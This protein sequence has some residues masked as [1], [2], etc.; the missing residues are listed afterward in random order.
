MKK[1]LLTRGLSFASKKFFSGSILF[2]LIILSSFLQKASAQ[3]TLQTSDATSICLGESTTINVKICGGYSPWTVVY[4]DGTNNYTVT[5]YSSNCDPDAGPEV[6]DDITV[7]P[8]VTSTYTLVSVTFGGGLALETLSGSVTVTVNPLPTNIVVSPAAGVCPGVNFEIS[9]TATNGSTYE[10]WNAANTTKIDDLPYTTSITSNTNYTVRAISSHGCVASQSYTALLEDTPPS[11]SNPGAQTVNPVVGTCATT[12]PDYRSLVTVSDNCTATGSIALVQSPVAGTAISGHGTVQLVRITATDAAG[13]SNFSEFNVTLIDNIDPAISCVVNQTV[14]AS[15]SCT[16]T[17]SGTAWNPSG[18]DN[19]SVASVTYS[20]DNGATP[21]TGTTLN[22]VEFQPGTTTVTWTVTDGAGNTAECSFDVSIE[23]LQKP[24][25][26][27]YEDQ[28]ATT[29]AGLCS[30]TINTSDWDVSAE[31]NCT[32]ASV[33]YVLSGETSGT[34]TATLSGTTFNKGVTTVNVTVADGAA[35]P[36]TET[37]SFTVTISDNENPTIT[38]P[39]DISENVLSGCSKSI[40]I[41]TIVFG[42]NC[43]GSS[44]TWSSTGAT[45]LSGSGQPGAQTFDVGTT[46]VVVEVTDAANHKTQCS[47]NVVVSDNIEPTVTCPEDISANTDEGEN[48]ATVTVPDIAFSDNCTTAN[49]A[50][51]MSGATTRSGSDQIG[52]QTFSVGVTTVE[53]TVTDAADNVSTCSFDVTVT[54]NQNPVVTCPTPDAS[55]SADAGKCYKTLSFTATA[56][57]NC[58]VASIHYY[59]GS[60]ETQITFPYNF[61]VGSTEV[62]ARATDIN[63][64]TG[65][66]TF[67]VLVVDDQKPIISGCPS[68][69]VRSSSAGVCTAVVS[70]TEPTATDNCTA[71]ASLVKYRSHVPGSTFNP[72]IT[73]VKYAFTDVAG[74]VSDTCSFT[75]E[76]V[77]NQKPVI[78]GCPSNMTVYTSSGSCTATATWTEPTATDNCTSSGALVWTK[79]HSPGATFSTGTTTVTYTVKDGNENISNPCTFTVTVL[80]NVAPTAVCKN[81]TIDLNSSGN[82]TLTAVAVNNESSDNC[83]ATESLLLTLSKTS[84]NCSNIGDNT[85]TLTVRDASG[86]QA[87]CNSTVTVRDVTAPTITAT[88]GTV[89][90]TVNATSGCEYA[91]LGSEFDPVVTDNCSSVTKNY[92]VTGAT[93]LSGSG[94]LAGKVLNK[95]ANV[96]TWTA[97]DGSSNTTATPL[98][99]TKTVVDNQAPVLTGKSNQTRLTDDGYCYYTVQST[100]FDITYSD[101]CGV[102]SV[103]Y[104]VSGATTISDT[105]TLVGKQLN[106]GTNTIVWTVSDGANSVSTSFKVTVSE[107]QPP[108]ITQISDINTEVDEGKCTATVSWTTPTCTE[109]CSLISLLKVAGP[110]SGSDFSVGTT[111]IRYIAT[112]NSGNKDTMDFHV[113]V[114]DNTPPQITCPSGSTESE[115]FVRDAGTGVC[116]Y[117]VDDDEFDPS[118][119]SDGLGC[120]VTATNSFDGT[121]TLAG[122]QIP[123][124]DYD[125]TWTASDGVNTSTC[126]I[127]VSVVD[128]QDPTFTV[129]SGTFAEV[130]D[131]DS[132]TFTI[133]GTDYDPADLTDNCGIKSSTYII[134]KNG[135]QTH[136]GSNTLSDV[137]LEADESY[138][139]VITWTVIDDNDNIVV[140]TPF[141]VS[142]SDNQAPSFEC[143]GNVTRAKNY[144]NCEYEIQ[145]DEFDPSDLVD[146]CDA[147]GDLTISYKLDGN[148][149]ESSSLDGVVLSSAVHT[150]VWTVTD[151]W[152]NSTNCTFKVTVADDE[153][154][155]FTST[156][157][158]QEKDAPDNV[159]YY[160][161]VGTE[162]DPTA[163]DNCGSVTLTHNQGGA[164]PGTL[165]GYQFP[166]GVT[167]VVWTAK[168]ASNN[169]STQE[170]EVVVND[171]TAPG[172]DL[173]YD[174]ND[175][176]IVYASSTSCYYTASGKEFDP[177]N[178]DDN[179]TSDVYGAFNDYNG[180]RS[181]AFA[182]FPVGVNT[183]TWDVSDNYGNTTSKTLDVVVYDTVAPVINCPATDYV[184]VVDNNKDYYTVGSG[185]FRPVVTDNCTMASFVNDYNSLSTL[186]GVQLSIGEHEITWTAVDDSGNDTQCTVTIYVVS[187]VYP[188]ISC[189]GDKLVSNTSGDCSYTI[190]SGAW[191]AST[192]STIATLEHNIQTTNPNSLPYALSSTT[193]NGAIF[194]EGTEEVIWTA[195]QVVAGTTYTSE[196]NFYITVEDDQLPTISAPADIIVNTDGDCYVSTASVTLGTPSVDDNCGTSSPYNNVASVVSYQGYPLGTTTITWWIEDIHGNVSSDTQTVTVVDDDAPVISCP[197]SLCRQEDQSGGEGTGY[198]TV[199]GH[200]FDPYGIWDCSGPVTKTHN[201]SG[202]PS[203]TTLAGA[204]FSVGTHTV[205]WTVVDAAE[206]VTTCQISITIY[207]TDPPSVTCR[208]YEIRDTDPGVCTYLAKNGEFDISSTT[209][210]APTITYSLS[211]ATVGSGGSSLDGVT[212]ERGVTTVTWIA[213]D[214]GNSE[215]QNICCTFTVTVEDNEDPAVTWPQDTTVYA[216]SGGCSYSGLDVGVPVAD[217]NC[218][219]VTVVIYPSSTATTYDVGETH[220]YWTVHDGRGNY[221]THTQTITVIDSISPVI[222]CPSS[223]YYREYDNSSVSYYTIDGTEFRPARSDNCRVASYTNDV[224]GWENTSLSGYTL[225]L[226]EHTITWTAAD[227]NTTPAPN[228]SQCTLDIVIVDSFDPLLDCPDDVTI[229]STSNDCNG[230]ISGT[231]YDPAWENE[232]EISGRTLVHNI[233]TANSELLPY[234]P[235]ESTLDGAVFDFGTTT[236]TWTATQN[237]GGTDYTSTCDVDITVTDTTPPVMDTP[238]DDITVQVDPGYC[239]ATVTLTPPTATDNCTDAEDIT[240]TSDVNLLV[241]LLVGTTNVHWTFTDASGNSSYHTQAIT[242]QDNEA[243]IISNCPAEDIVADAIGSSCQAVVPWAQLI[244]TDACSGIDTFYSSHKPGTLF[245]VGTTTVTYTAIDNSTNSSTCI[246]NVVVND[247]A[248]TISCVSDT[249]RNTNPGYCSYKVLGNEFD[250]LDFDDNC[251]IDT[252]YWSFTDGNGYHEGGN[253]L[254]GVRIERLD[255]TDGSPTPVVITWT[256]EDVGGNTATC[257]F[258]LTIY[259]LEGPKII[260]P[261]NAV[262]YTD[263]YHN[264]YT[265]QGTEFDDVT[266]TDNCG[267]VVKLENEYLVG[268]LTSI[269]LPFGSN[270]ITWYAEDDKGN[271]S[272]Q[273]FHVTVLDTLSPR[274]KTEPS[275]IT[276]SASDTCTTVVS[277]VAPLFEDNVTSL[278]YLESHTTVS[279]AEAI[280]GYAFPVGVTEVTYLVV[281]SLGNEFSYTFNITVED[282][283]DPVLTC[284]ASLTYD[285]YTETDKSYYVVNNDEFNATV[286]DNCE[287]TLTNSF[288]SSSTLASAWLPIGENIITWT[289]EDAGGNT[290]TCSITINVIDTV[291][292]VIATCS[293]ATVSKDADFGVCYYTIPGSEYDPFGFDDNYQLDSITYNI[294]G[295]GEVGTD[296]TT[297]LSGVQ[298]PVGE[299][300]IVWKLYDTSG[301]FSS[302]TITF[303]VTDTQ[304]PIIN[305]VADQTRNTDAGFDYYTILSGDD[306]DPEITD[307]CEVSVITYQINSETPVGTDKTTSIIGE[308]LPIGTDTIV[309]TATDIHGNSSTGS[310]QVIVAD[311]DAPTAVCNNITVELGSDGTYTLTTTDINA[312]GLGSTDG[313]GID[314]LTVSPDM[315]TCV[316]VGDN[317]VQLTVTD[318]YLNQATCDATVTVEDNIA[319]TAICRPDSLYLDVLGS[320]TISATT[321]NNSSTDNCGIASLEISKDSSTFATSLDYTCAESGVNDIYL[322]VTDNNGNSSVCKTTVKIKDENNPNAVCN[323]ITVYLDINGEYTLSA[324]NIDSIAKGSSDNCLQIISKEVVPNTFDCSDI[325]ETNTVTLTVMDPGLHTDA[326]QTTITV[327][328]TVPPTAICK[329]I[330]LELDATGNATLNP[331]DLSNNSVD[332][333]GIDTYSA[334]QTSFDCNDKGDHTITLT[335]TDIYGNY[336][337]CTSN[338]TVADSVD[339]G[340]TCSVS[341]EQLVETNED[342]CTYTHSGTGWNAT[343]NDGCV[344]VASLTYSLTGET[345]VADA[346]GN[347]SLN[348]VVFNKGITTVTW[349]AVDG[350]GNISTCSFTVN[351][352]DNQLPSPVCKNITVLLDGTGSVTIIPEDVDD[353]SADNCPNFV[354]SL[355]KTSFDCTN[356]G[357]NTVTLTVTDEDGNINTCTATVTVEDVT[358][359]VAVCQDITVQLDALGSVTVNGSDVNNNSTDNSTCD[360]TYLVSTTENGTFASTISYDCDSVGSRTLY[361]MVQ[362]SAGNSSLAACSSTIT[363]QDTV[364]PIASCKDITVQL[365]GIGNA[366]ITASQIDNGS[367]DACGIQSLVASQTSFT[368]ANL[369]ANT[370]TLTVTDVNTNQS[371]CDA[372]VTVEDNVAPVITCGVTGNQAVTT[373]SACT[374]LHSGTGWDATATDNCDASPT[375]TYT[376]SAPSTLTLPNTTLDGQAFE[377]GTTTVTWTAFDA[378]GN[379][380]TCSFTVTVTDDDNPVAACTP[381]TIELDRLGNYTLTSGDIDNISTGSTDNCGIITKVVSP[382]TYDCLNIITPVAVTLTI[383]D[384]AGLTAT[385]PTTVTVTDTQKPTVDAEDIAD[386]TF[387]ADA[388][389]TYTHS[390]TGWDPTDNCDSEPTISYSADNGASPASGNSLHGVVFQKGTTHVTWTVADHASTPNT[391]TV[392]FD[393]VV[394]DNEDPEFTVCPSNITKTV[395]LAGDLD[396]DIED[397]DGLTASEYSDNCDVT[398]FKWIIT[399]AGVVAPA[400][401]VD[402]VSSPEAGLT[403]PLNGVDFKIGTSTVKYVVFDAAG[404]T[405]TC[406][407]TITVNSRETNAITVSGGPI[408]TYEDQNEGA[409]TF[410]VVLPAAPTG[411]VCID[412]TSSDISEG[413]VATLDNRVTAASSQTICFNEANWETPQTIYVFGVDDYVDQDT[414]AY[415]IVLSINSENTD[416]LSGYIDAN[417]DDVS[418]KNIDNDT[419]GI[420]VTPVDVL[421]SEDGGTGSFTVVLNTEPTHDVT[422]TLSSSDST[423]CDVLDKTTLTF[424]PSNWNTPQLV[425]VTG[426]DENIVDG[427]VDFDIITSTASSTD[428]KYNGMAVDDVTFTNEDNDVAGVTVTPLTL[429]TSENETTATFT[430]VLNSKPATDAEDYDVY[431]DIASNNLAE[432]TVDLSQLHFTAANWNIPDTVTVTG[433][434]E[435]PGSEVVDGSIVFTIVNTI[436]TTLTTDS[437]YDPIN[438]DDVTVTN[439]DNDT[440]TVAINSVALAEGSSVPGTTAFTFTITQTGPTVIGGYSVSW[441]TS[442]TGS[443]KTPSDFTGTGGTVTFTEAE[444]IN[445]GTKTVTVLVNQDLMVEPNETFPVT[446]GSILGASGKAVSIPVAGKVGTGTINND[447]SSVFTINDVSITEGDSG[448]KLLTFTVSLSNPVELGATVQYTTADNTATDTDNDYEPQ[449]GT[450]SFPYVDASNS[451]PAQTISITI[452]GD[453]KV[454]LDETFY[455]NLSNPLVNISSPATDPNVTISDAQGVGTITND[456]AAT[457]TITDAI[458]H[459]EGNIG[460]TSYE[461]TV[462][463]S[464]ASDANVTV[465][466]TSVN[467]TAETGDSDY[468]GISGT[469]T[470]APGETTKTITVLVNGD[471]EVELDETFTVE[472]SNLVNNGRA[473]T[474]PEDSDTGTGT[475]T[476]DDQATLAIG[477]VTITEGDS[478]TQLLTFTVTHSGSSIDAGFTVDYTTVDSI[479]QTSDNDYDAA[480]GTLSFSGATGESHSFTVTINGDEIVERDEVFKAVLSNIQAG[481]RNVVF[482]KDMAT[483]TIENDDAALFTIDDVTHDEGNSGTTNYVFTVSLDYASDTTVTV[484]FTTTNG[485][486][487]TSDNDYTLTSGTLTFLAGETSKTITVPVTGD[488]TV[489]LDEE[490]TVDLSGVVSYGRDVT[491]DDGSGTGTI[492]NDDQAVV[493]ITDVEQDETDSGQTTFRFTVTLSTNSDATTTVH[494]ETFDGTATVAD[495]DYDAQTGTLTFLAGE[496]VKYIDILVNGDTKVELD[497]IFTI[498]LDNLTVDGRN[499]IMPAT[500]GTG[501]IQND[502][503][504]VISVTGFT[505]NEADGT[506]TF[507]ISMTNEVQSAFTVDFYTSNNTALSTSDYTAVTTTT[508]NFGG[509]NDLV[510]YITVPITNDIYVEPTETLYGIVDNKI[511]AQNQSVTLSGGGESTQDT[512]T[513]EDDDEAY[514]SIDNVTE[515]EPDDGYTDVYMFTVTHTGGT[516]DGPF[517]V[518][519]TT[520][521]LIASAGTDYVAQSG[522]LTFSG[523]SGESHTISITV[524]GDLLVEPTETFTVDLSE[525]NFGG[526]DITFTDNSGLGTIT[527][528]DITYVSIAAT[529]DGAEPDVDGLFTVSM[530]FESTSNTV[531]SYT[532]SGTATSGSDFTALSGTVT[533]LAGELSAT[534]PVEVLN[535]AVLEETETVI[536]TLQNIVFGEDYVFIGSPNPATIYITD[537]DAA[538]TAFAGANAEICSTTT[539]YT[540]SDATSSNTDTYA[541]TTD[542]T[543]SFDDNSV[544]NATYN[545]S[546]GDIEDGQVTL[547]LT[548]SG[549]GGTAT[550]EMILTIWKTA[551]AYA[552][553]DATLCGTDAYEV[554]DAEATNYESLLWTHDGN[555]SLSGA[556]TLTPTYTPDAADTGN[557]V[558]LTLTATPYGGG[559]CINVVDE[560]SFG[561]NASI[562]LSSPVVT[563]A[564]CAG[565][566]TGSVALGVSSGGTSPYT[567]ALSTGESKVHPRLSVTVTT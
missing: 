90:S 219:D 531:I 232:M 436:N 323:P 54:D 498:D 437:N 88:T 468:T 407:F 296:L 206:N 303:T 312:I 144:G 424:T 416:E 503:S 51:E 11:I 497:E 251:D 448:T 246:F 77:D 420:T 496:T 273:D 458:T 353:G 139:Y 487:L 49:L 433:V 143:S 173:D 304:A 270:D 125:I 409:A 453:E 284:P 289:A 475:I 406:T 84:F 504:A 384:A 55:Y 440:A 473:I 298:I 4:T 559:T 121:N 137:A 3:A 495:G 17:H 23:D 276:V 517:T 202:T 267:I 152:D 321:I 538:A 545:P 222:T 544:L 474:L 532:V 391:G 188:P 1:S 356:L 79:S 163:Q 541:W 392:E 376:V 291:P 386:L 269:Q 249:S 140:A 271:I 259:D 341:G 425:T 250:P 214:P 471:T 552:G 113:I 127:Y 168:D 229:T 124:G 272:T 103:K 93:T 43:T 29:D 459:N 72:G 10:L 450:L 514:L 218:S 442:N 65:D 528:K 58:G 447:D 325:G 561:V 123:V 536:I 274:V 70:W 441:Y 463:L 333:C 533:I 501:T 102:T 200:E 429:N 319:P 53:L 252:V 388:N 398:K 344:T 86:N 158:N 71:S 507:T 2:V 469:L 96:I 263:Y 129:P 286:T 455:I 456:D 427:D 32:V 147:I 154:P 457:V 34:V 18:S 387:D 116:F 372:T 6:G 410:T 445:E 484:D 490:F 134:T 207:N 38:C 295:T 238:F 19:C 166:V 310:Y 338:V 132:C 494:F 255:D 192:T 156:I 467:G 225:D 308:T 78:S 178:I 128:N 525:G 449:T 480:S 190:G 243:P 45:E 169:I 277:Y 553:E 382:N 172:F 120:S 182:Q 237:I 343:A 106:P 516:T 48:F 377:V 334:S 204:T 130:S 283:T 565:G 52:E 92:T 342:F 401:A 313:S 428:P 268:T 195:T 12:I 383:T 35:T 379:T 199:Y 515:T 466:Y 330:V 347:T 483:G 315:F 28:T 81:V 332:A 546:E 430:V 175:S 290:Q 41:P 311:N 558:T 244:A 508:L 563:D 509:S 16:Y 506:G 209:T 432:G 211:G 118:A 89:T 9:A 235:S 159:C 380:S 167:V 359:P 165:A 201:I 415:N 112:D 560:V 73:T 36:N 187:S 179:C 543:G 299:N 521:D 264:Y 522:T 396:V 186:T 221:T 335:V 345:V 434:D 104:T 346:P 357:D 91:V 518:A 280:P 551:T 431:V 161:A 306:F 336:S 397:A 64:L 174:V 181:L 524:N 20:A 389:C 177:Q 482:T 403:N 245:G 422:I 191:D 253:T 426:K 411:D 22:N 390:G 309:W 185:E 56:T 529:T 479:A 162:F 485:T 348:N 5:N 171:I 300:T 375:I 367:T 39:D 262:R 461:F 381:I 94:S 302:C 511:D 248:P 76:V 540:L 327:L 362:D 279:P 297:S 523:A 373:N 288:N 100:E 316:D 566:E 203:T 340:I 233:Q 513:I 74:N 370:V 464:Y 535:D 281:D 63:G 567:Y 99:F 15:A 470:F 216:Q 231:D 278:S 122:K 547:T 502:D 305:P 349:T 266:A 111:L 505:V 75:V 405:D 59:I 548:A 224:T 47:F 148:T 414:V 489:E 418:A 354:L 363:V 364:S 452:N 412:V 131:P 324:T 395:D 408:I 374:Y 301:N 366:T 101:N 66:C 534:I 234:A 443:A 520:N 350:S 215:I 80:D 157:G 240:I 194:P 481:G 126:T 95:G 446:L 42:D 184:R 27:A 196:C 451:N 320:A 7:T 208:G 314:T 512:G 26:T 477:D 24:T 241:P 142:V 486:A 556:T 61:P 108:V 176:V 223:T 439:A 419:A 368:C 87:T 254:S 62:T 562:V 60:P 105:L 83:T 500:T 189:V 151:T 285:V 294:N 141:S 519:Y 107:T 331:Q 292:P 119:Y 465:D 135:V 317:I 282:E 472:L 14:P 82:A 150:I 67:T 399:G 98:T 170:F 550:D 136:S 242:V 361:L 329:D 493:A 555:G 355:D 13:N 275:G 261:G 491:I 499:V 50:W 198:Y 435:T 153:A 337:T 476:N 438:P 265:I 404:N 133:P 149:V 183:V 352:E 554:T 293:D 193:L 358:P 539:S 371:T 247:D 394:E 180:Y 339:P 114:T 155:E 318:I 68:N 393:V 322:K 478:G 526:R 492:T 462:T 236:V 145:G 25:I 57:D 460:T 402:S 33:T 257:S 160:T 164:T 351:V 228:T 146:N 413:L 488:N 227:A 30:Y 542:G 326:C 110:D 205:T 564:N 258:N 365:D 8:T 44:I 549:D 31:D 239:Y 537:D 109:N 400:N 115:P 37:C 360:L 530:P 21:A 85:V 423:E 213:T 557:T 138:P 69:I 46:I 256:A 287:A 212:F 217:D 260:V 226:G 527:D 117:T 444:A 417:P 197:A 454:E 510:Q 369:G 307:N 220:I 97:T 328:D 421:T 40:T 385:C 378:E 210:P 230:T